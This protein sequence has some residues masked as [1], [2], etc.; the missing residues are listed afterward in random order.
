MKK[1]C[2]LF[3]NIESGYVIFRYI[4]THILHIYVYVCTLYWCLSD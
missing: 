4:Y 1:I 3:F 2:T